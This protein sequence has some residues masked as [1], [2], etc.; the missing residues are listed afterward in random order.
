MRGSGLLPPQ[1][2][3]RLTPPRLFADGPCGRGAEEDLQGRLPMHPHALPVILVLPQSWL[4][5]VIGS[6]LPQ[7]RCKVPC[8]LFKFILRI[9][10]GAGWEERI[11]DTGFLEEAGWCSC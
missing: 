7:A 5:G 8:S 1:A 2:P 9:L 3:S 11:Q 10:V 4:I 6:R